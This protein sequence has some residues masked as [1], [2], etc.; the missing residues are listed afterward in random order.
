MFLRGAAGAGSQQSTEHRRGWAVLAW[1]QLSSALGYSPPLGRYKLSSSAQL[2]FPVS[3][4]ALP[5]SGC[6][7]KQNLFIKS[8]KLIAVLH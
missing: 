5:Q 2:C 7:V 4:S 6:A 1:L 8:A 3:Q